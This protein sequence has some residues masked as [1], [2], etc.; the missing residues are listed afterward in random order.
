MSALGVITVHYSYSHYAS[1]VSDNS[2]LFSLRVFFQSLHFLLF[3]K[4]LNQYL[5]GATLDL[6]LLQ[7][8]SILVCKIYFRFQFISHAVVYSAN[9]SLHASLCTYARPY[10]LA[11]VYTLLDT[12]NEKLPPHQYQVWCSSVARLS[13]LHI[14]LILVINW[15]AFRYYVVLAL[16]WPFLRTIKVVPA[17][18]AFGQLS[19]NSNKFF[20][21]IWPILGPVYFSTPVH[22]SI[23]I[24]YSLLLKFRSHSTVG[25]PSIPPFPCSCATLPYSMLGLKR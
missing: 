10:S 19:Y 12:L 1:L 24:P 23:P 18:H 21:R 17:T 13:T 11:P 15:F 7:H 14:A 8:Q 16:F 9:R 25:S 3:F 2:L 20:I 6:T 5:L 22:W 4:F